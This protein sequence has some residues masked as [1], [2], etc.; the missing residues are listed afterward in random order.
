MNWCGRLIFLSRLTLAFSINIAPSMRLRAVAHSLML[1]YIL[2]HITTQLVLSILEK[3]T[4]KCI[5]QHAN[6]CTWTRDQRAIE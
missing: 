3:Q 1:K 2:F 4:H 6:D 5:S